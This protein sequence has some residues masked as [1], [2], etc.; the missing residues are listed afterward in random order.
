MFYAIMRSLS[1][2]P[3][4]PAERFTMANPH[5]ILPNRVPGG[6]KR[7]VWQYIA[8]DI[9]GATTTGWSYFRVNRLPDLIESRYGRTYHPATISRALRALVDE[10]YITYQPGSRGHNSMAQLTPDHTRNDHDD[11]GGA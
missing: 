2:L 5:R 1:L 9:D 6:A 10:G 3:L 4:A 8:D 7:D 11:G